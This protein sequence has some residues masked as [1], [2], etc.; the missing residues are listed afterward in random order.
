MC[1]TREKQGAREISRESAERQRGVMQRTPGEALGQILRT[2][3]NA[4]REKVTAKEWT[5]TKAHTHTHSR[6]MIFEN[7]K[8]DCRVA[9]NKQG[10]QKGSGRTPSRETQLPSKTSLT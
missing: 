3:L 10:E 8:A 7:R 9:R 5:E 2:H 1:G 6:S 4:K